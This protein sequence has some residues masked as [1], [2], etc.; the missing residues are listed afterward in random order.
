MCNE[1]EVASWDP[2]CGLLFW[3]NGMHQMGFHFHPDFGTRRNSERS[4][5]NI[6]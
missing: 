3:V 2:L 6:H 5:V 1:K 4:K